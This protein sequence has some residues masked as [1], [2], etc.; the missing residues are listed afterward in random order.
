ML[1][2]LLHVKKVC[3]ELSAGDF[4]KPYKGESEKMLNELRNRA[5]CVPWRLCVLFI[6]EIESCVADRSSEKENVDKSFIGVFLSILDGPKALHNLKIIG[7]TNLRDII[8]SA[9]MRRLEK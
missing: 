7:T 3:K 4:S 6:D 9:I 1:L 8:D 5:V 2:E